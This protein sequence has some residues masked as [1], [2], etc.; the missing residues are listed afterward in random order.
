MTMN[1]AVQRVESVFGPA[2]KRTD[3]AF[4][5]LQREH[6]ILN[7]AQKRED[8][9]PFDIFLSLALMKYR[10]RPILVTYFDQD[11]WN[12]RSL[13]EAF[14]LDGVVSFIDSVPLP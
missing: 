11:K 6:T 8:D 7:F 9:T 1:E 13:K 4:P 3:Y 12:V 2:F 5:I 10:D 14:G